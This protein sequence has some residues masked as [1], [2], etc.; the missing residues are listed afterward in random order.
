MV[1]SRALL[2]VMGEGALVLPLSHSSVS[3]LNNA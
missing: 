2:A 1:S 3:L